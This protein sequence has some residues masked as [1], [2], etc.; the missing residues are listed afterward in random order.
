MTCVGGCPDGF[1]CDR[2]V[3][4]SPDGATVRLCCT[5]DRDCNGNGIPDSDDIASGTS[6]DCNVNL[7]PDECDVDPTDPDG[8]GEISADC[9]ENSV[10]DDC[11]IAGGADDV[12]GGRIRQASELGQVAATA[13]RRSRTAQHDRVQG[14]IRERNV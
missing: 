7:I 8:N 12:G 10:P 11:D 1:A 5:C 3:D 6:P 9:D 4:I 2:T 13:E 14:R